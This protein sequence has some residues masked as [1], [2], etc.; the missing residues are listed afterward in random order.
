MRKIAILSAAAFVLGLAAL[1][2]APKASAECAGHGKQTAETPVSGQ[3][4]AD[5]STVQTTPKP[6]N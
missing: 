1:G 2:F 6:G 5:S 3:S 4:V